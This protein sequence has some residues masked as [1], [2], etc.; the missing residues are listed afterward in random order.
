MSRPY[1]PTSGTEG[2][3]FQARFCENCIHDAGFSEAHPERGCQ[4]LAAT[5]AFDIND[6]EYPK[7]WIVDD[8]GP[9][10]TMFKETAEA[11]AEGAD[12]PEWERRNHG[13][14]TPRCK[15]TVDMF[16]EDNG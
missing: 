10:C 1:R 13:K 7:E 14:V 6:P 8:D 12:A 15:H 2:E 11:I 5:M 9:R 4:I 16:G 3:S